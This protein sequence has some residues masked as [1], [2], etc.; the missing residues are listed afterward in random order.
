M[1]DEGHVQGNATIDR[2]KRSRAWMGTIWTE[3]DKEIMIR[4]PS[5]YKI[6]SDN[7]YTSEGQLH[8]HCLITTKNANYRPPTTTAHWEPCIDRVSARKYCLDKGTDFIEEGEFTV[9]CGNERDWRGFV[10][11]CKKNTPHEMIDGPYSMMF[12]RFRG[13]AGEVHN[14]FAELKPLEGP[15]DNYWLC[16]SAGTGKT[17]WAYDNNP[18]L[19]VKNINKWWDGYNLEDTVLLDDWDPRHEMLTQH[20]KIW[21]DRYVFRG[22][23]KGSSMLCRPKRIIV[24]SNF[25]I[26]ECF[27]KP[28]DVEAIKRRFKVKHFWR[29]GNEFHND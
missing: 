5:L 1:D 16:G 28:E 19:Y 14:Q 15:L 6:I 4:F 21:A 2:R 9:N 24:T 25:T 26:E 20:L 12:A 17:R 8:W 29:L 7:D 27:S 10:D 11:A 13:F 22:E 3:S 23:T 18:N